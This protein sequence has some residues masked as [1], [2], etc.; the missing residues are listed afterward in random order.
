M[1][2]IYHHQY[3]IGWFVVVLTLLAL[4]SAITNK[5]QHEQTKTVVEMNRFFSA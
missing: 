4:T 1:H 3:G 5:H 2:S